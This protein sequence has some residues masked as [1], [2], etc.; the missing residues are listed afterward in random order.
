MNSEYDNIIKMIDYDHYFDREIWFKDVLKAEYDLIVKDGFAIIIEFRV[1]FGYKIGHSRGG[2]RFDRKKKNFEDY[3]KFVDYLK[4]ELQQRKYVIL[5]IDFMES[6][7]AYSKIFEKDD[8]FRESI[9][10]TVV[11]YPKENWIEKFNSKKRYDLTYAKKKNLAE[12]TF[13]TNVGEETTI[14][15]EI[16][17]QLYGLISFAYKRHQSSFPIP[18]EDVFLRIF[19][20]VPY[21]LAVAIH[22]NN[23][24]AF[25]LSLYNHTMTRVERVYAGANEDAL[26][27]RIPSAIEIDMV[28]YLHKRGVTYYDLWGIRREEHDGVGQFKRSIGDETIFFP[29]Y[30]IMRVH[31]FLASLL[32]LSM[33]ISRKIKTYI[34]RYH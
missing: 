6:E 8:V 18:T 28:D 7:N 5:G 19:K 31:S 12:I 32:I 34:K 29:E 22:E 27:L 15:K 16:I 4:K 13:F 11:I 23:C 9:P 2:I 21:I 25:N 14:P 1:R 26:R 3:L 30:G 24:I 33:K 20:H 17:T 10:G